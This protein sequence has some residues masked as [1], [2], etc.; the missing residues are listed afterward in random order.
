MA[1][2]AVQLHPQPVLP[3][4]ATTHPSLSSSNSVTEPPPHFGH[5]RSAAASCPTPLLL[6]HPAAAAAASAELWLM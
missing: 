2:R 4:L 5:T 1:S 6:P 3:Q